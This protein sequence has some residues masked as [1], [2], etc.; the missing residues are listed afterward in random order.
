MRVLSH[1]CCGPCYTAVHEI[2]GQAG[3][4][5][6]VFYYNPNIHPADEYRRRLAHLKR[7]CALNSVPAIIGEYETQD[8]FD[9]VGGDQEQPDRCIRCYRL[10]L[11][12]T[13]ETAARNDYD[14]FTTSLLLSPY[15][16]HDELREVGYEVGRDFG[17]EFL[18]RDFRPAYR[19]SI[20]LSKAFE[21]YRQKYCGCVFSEAERR[22]PKPRA[23]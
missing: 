23:G 13:V 9:A 3:H 10:R 14:A 2:L 22:E 11:E 21:M 15:Q 6:A 19:R 8:Y 18:Y 7:F 5:Q 20:E 17:V 4:D 1:V 12:R 16:Y